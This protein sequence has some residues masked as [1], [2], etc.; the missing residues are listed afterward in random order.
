MIRGIGGRPYIDLDPYLDVDG[1]KNLHPEICRGFALAREYAKEGTWMHPAFDWGD[2][3]YIMNWK[4]IYRAFEEFKN[5]DDSDPIKVE[6]MKLWP[7]DF[8]NFKQRNIFVRYLK[9]AMGAHDPYIYYFL[10]ED[11]TNMS[12][13]GKSQRMPTQEQQ[14]FP[15]V[16]SWINN[17]KNNGIIEYIGRV[18]FFVCESGSKPFEHRDIDHSTL[19]NSSGYSNHNI[20]FIHIRPFLRRGFYVWNPKHRVKTYVNS[21]S[22]F[23][24]DQDWHGAEHGM[25]QDY[26]LRID[27]KFTPEFRKLVG[28]DHLTHY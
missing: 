22:C 27:C 14:H 8:K 7:L 5:L 13:R 6:G 16:V 11:T 28:I 1:F 12:D 10:W 15:G 20:E 25:E 21:H 9:S 19:G 17:L 4:P 18:L 3:S 2:S 26:S 24:N 23:F